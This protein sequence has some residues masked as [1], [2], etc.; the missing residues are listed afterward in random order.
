MDIKLN[1]Q[2]PASFLKEIEIQKN[3][4][5]STEQNRKNENITVTSIQEET[6]SI[7]NSNDL[8]GYLKKS[9]KALNQ[10][11]DILKESNSPDEFKGA[12]ASVID[13]TTYKNKNI[14]ESFRQD[15]SGTSTDL[16]KSIRS[17]IDGSDI[18]GLN[19]LISGQKEITAS[20]LDD[21]KKELLGSSNSLDRRISTDINTIK[22]DIESM[23]PLSDVNSQEH[24]KSKLKAL[25]G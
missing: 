5:N 17:L 11:S 24:L 13:V 2:F 22:K 7:K 18:E 6:S 1:S 21:V 25:L 4:N 12:I 10:I 9:E 14:F 15:A 20:L 8:F 23:S 16:G 19:S 3:I